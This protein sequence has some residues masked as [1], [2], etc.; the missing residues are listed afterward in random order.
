MA[1][2]S[3][4]RDIPWGRLIMPVLSPNLPARP[5]RTP[6]EVALPHGSSA[7]QQLHH[8]GPDATVIA[9]LERPQDAVLR[10]GKMGERVA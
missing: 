4:A 1:R 8:K 6:R 7:A 5:V 10:F 3:T 2:S 9:I